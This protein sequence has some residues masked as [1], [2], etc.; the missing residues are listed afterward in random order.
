MSRKAAEKGQNAAKKD[1]LIERAG[2]RTSWGF[3]ETNAGERSPPVCFYDLF[4]NEAA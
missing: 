3:R 4:G 2:M 1:P